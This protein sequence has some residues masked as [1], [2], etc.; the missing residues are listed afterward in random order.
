VTEVRPEIEPLLADLKS[1]KQ[2]PR[3]AEEAVRRAIAESP[4]LNNLLANAA[5]EG[6][7]ERIAISYG[8]HNGG[9]FQDATK[10]SPPT[11]F[12]SASNFKRFRHA[13]LVDRLT[14]VLGHETM[15]G[16]LSDERGK[17][18]AEFKNTYAD[19]LEAAH[20]SRSGTVNLTEPVRKFLEKGR[21]DEAL[22]EVSG[23]RAMDSRLRH[24]HPSLG[25]GELESLLAE[26]SLSRCIRTDGD[27]RALA[28]GVS[29]EALSNR[30][31]GTSVQLTK[32]VEQCFY[33]GKGSLGR[34]GDSDYR[35][36]YGTYPLS[37]IGSGHAY[38]TEV[39][40]APDIRIDLH[41]LGLDPKQ[42]ERNGLNFGGA[43]E[44]AVADYGKNGLGWVQLR[45]TGSASVTAPPI[46]EVP[47]RAATT[48]ALSTSDQT[49]L[50]QI[51]SKVG[52][53]DQANGRTFDETSERMSASLLAAAKDAGITQ[54]DHV[55]LSKQTA[56]SPAAQNIFVVQGDLADPA[57][58]RIHLATADAAQ[59]PVQES[60]S[61]VEAIG[62]RQVR[63]QAADM[64]RTQ[65][66]QR[67][68]A[69]SL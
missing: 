26:R 42:L 41:E 20:A 40:K 24:L 16:V 7:V 45:N 31:D 34:F 49:L 23:L 1:D 69:P 68:S 48:S 59:R 61:Q 52:Q 28:Q 27:S 19:E 57:A 60:M 14:E 17:A 32:G 3:G 21:Q 12:V 43:K 63:E 10:D 30:P 55:V 62:Q 66:Q 9:H 11:I 67:V 54:A 4:Y 64:Q 47:E 65:D 46:A 37:V 35:N 2:L 58:L 22:S 6:Q 44:L 56:T 36:Y 15:H 50:D 38:L 29:Y 13:E 33:D 53:L 18:L 51:G 39:R 5:K 25:D 8:H